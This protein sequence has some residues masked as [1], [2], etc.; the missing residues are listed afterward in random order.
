MEGT[1]EPASR[2]YQATTQREGA[3]QL[4]VVSCQFSV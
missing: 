4:S 1:I 3:V 2:A